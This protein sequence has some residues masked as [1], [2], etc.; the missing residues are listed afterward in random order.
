MNEA[1]K[2]Q[3]IEAFKKIDVKDMYAS[4]DENK[5]KW[6]RFGAFDALRI[7]CE[8]VIAMPTIEETQKDTK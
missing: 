3:L 6:F 2:K 4:E 5:R 7:A 8:L 1:T